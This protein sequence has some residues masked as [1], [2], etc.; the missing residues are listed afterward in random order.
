MKKPLPQNDTLVVT[1]TVLDLVR[2]LSLMMDLA[3]GRPQFHAQALAV[4]AVQLGHRV[5]LSPMHLGN[6]LVA[7]LLH[8]VNRTPQGNM[9]FLHSAEGA[10]LLGS[11][12]G[13]GQ[14][15]R[16]LQLNWLWRK[17]LPDSMR[18]QA[19]PLVW[20]VRLLQLADAFIGEVLPAPAGQG[21][22]PAA[23]LVRLAEEGHD[24]HLLSLL[25]ELWQ[26]ENPSCPLSIDTVLNLIDLEILQASVDQ[27]QV[28][29]GIAAFID[30]KSSWTLGHSQRVAEV[31]VELAYGLGLRGKELDFIHVCGL[32]HD[33]GK[34]AIP[35]ALLDKPGRLTKDEYGLVQSHA[36]FSGDILMRVPS[37][38]RHARVVRAHH[39]RWD[40]LGYP[41]GLMGENIPFEARILAVADSY[42]AMVSHRPYRQG[43]DPRL[44][45]RQIFDL[46]GGQFDP[47]VAEALFRLL[48]DQAQEIAQ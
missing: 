16:V 37:L 13:F 48:E 24:L 12:V 46:R 45:V 21:H 31:A 26:A 10:R 36:R 7:G 20:S 5:G 28:V 39:E 14:I 47:T 1:D 44:S 41:D 23:A 34:V 3:A 40:G 4:T 33:V 8:D 30:A 43:L 17:G 9:G 42:D 15:Q 22:S 29:Q 25:R 38:R 27:A 35:A 11:L 18:E 19:D 32:L 2:V 6:L